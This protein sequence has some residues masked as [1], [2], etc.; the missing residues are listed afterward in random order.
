VFTYGTPYSLESAPEGAG[1]AIDQY[2]ADLW[3]E[4]GGNSRT[5]NPYFAPAAAKSG[6]YYHFESLAHYRE[7]TGTKTIYSVWRLDAPS[8]ELA[9]GL[10]D[11]ALQ[12]ERGG[13]EG[14]VCIDRRQGSL[15]AV[16]ERSYG[17]GEWA[18]HRAADFARK[19]GFT[20]LEDA[21]EAEFGTS[22][23]PL[24]CDNAALYCGWY[25]LNHYNDAFTWSVGAIGWHL[26]SLSAVPRGGANWAANALKAGITI[27]NGSVAEPYLDAL[28]RPDGV[29]LDLF[30]GANVGDAFLRNT[31]WLKWMILNIGDPLYRPF[32]R[33]RQPFSNITRPMTN[34]PLPPLPR[35]AVRGTLHHAVVLGIGDAT[36]STNSGFVARP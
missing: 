21:N 28:T 8:A 23:A 18:L 13:L 35:A 11:K 27:T 12:A 3:D 29:F 34:P 36:G 30:E 6:H 31:R 7:R 16:E 22:P 20:V 19:A 32:P 5:P 15:D 10:V 26:D 2:V 4:T 14:Q 33:G 17:A 1:Q 25:A 24:R 9:N